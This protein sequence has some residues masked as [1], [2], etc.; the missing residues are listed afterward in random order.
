LYRYS[1]EQP[2]RLDPV[3]LY[4][5]LRSEEPVA[6]VQVPYGREAWLATRYDAVKSVFEDPRF[7]RALAAGPD[8]PRRGPTWTPPRGIISL[9]PPDHTRVRKLFAPAFS[10]RGVKRLRPRIEQIVAGLLDDLVIHGPPADL[11]TLLTK[12]VP[13]MVICEL[14]GIPYADRGEFGRAPQL[15]V[16]TTAHEVTGADKAW[17]GME[18][19]LRGLIAKRRERPTGDLFSALVRE[20]GSGDL[21]TEDELV[22][23][24]ELLLANGYE[25]TANEIANFIFVLLTHPDQLDWLRD[26]LSRVPKAV[27]ELLRFVPLAAGVPSAGGHARVATVD[28][29]LDG[30][31]IAAGEAVLPAINSANWDERVFAEP[32]RLDLDRENGHANLTFGHG[33]HH[34]LGAQLARV[35][36]QVILTGLLSRFPKLRLVLDSDEVPWKANAIQRGPTELLVAW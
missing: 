4:A 31:T 33:P 7:S 26:D 6:R 25:T 3:P 5:Q 10:M 30:V 13:V 24:A 34:C 16:S 18:D 2:Q 29:E 36:T 22:A 28:I 17:A 1:F 27:E 19:Y 32:D 9:D 20:A 21:I 14:L 23:M 11:I 15:L 35:Q 8:T 12:R